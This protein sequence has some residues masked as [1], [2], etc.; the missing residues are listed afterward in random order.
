MSTTDYVLSLLDPFDSRFPQP[1]I[2]DGSE[3]RSAGVRFR[4][5]GNITLPVDGSPQYVVLFPGFSYCLN[6][7][8]TSGAASMHAINPSHLGSLTLRQDIRKV[9]LVSAGLRLS[10]ENTSD[11]NEGNWEAVRIP[12]QGTDFIFTDAT[13]QTAEDFGVKLRDAFAMSD[14]ANHSTYQT[15]RLRD[16]HRFLFKLNSTDP[17]HDFVHV[18]PL[19]AATDPIWD[20][21]SSY[22]GLNNQAVSLLLDKAFDA[23]V[24]KITGRIDPTVPSVIRYDL[25]SNQEVVYKDGTALGRL[26]SLNTMF[27]QMDVILDK[28]RF[29]LPAIQAA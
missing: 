12:V 2:L 9:R 29:M 14:L 22:G 3:T 27:P 18:N 13:A 16:I 26:M 6:W 7:K 11:D 15:G 24:I 20:G 21:N 19:T 23:V 28:T 10:L 8:T 1:K 25:V 4:N 5:V 17:D